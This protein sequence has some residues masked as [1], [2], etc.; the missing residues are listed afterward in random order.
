M[1]EDDSKYKYSQN[2]NL[3]FGQVITNLETS[4]FNFHVLNLLLKYY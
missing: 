2:F 3:V 4:T 1:I